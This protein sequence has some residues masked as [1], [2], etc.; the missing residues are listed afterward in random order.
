M[1]SIPYYAL[2]ETVFAEQGVELYRA[3]STSDGK[4]VLLKIDQ[5]GDTGM[6][7]ARCSHEL[8]VA[9]N[10]DLPC[11]CRPLKLEY[12]GDTPVLVM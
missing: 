3:F 5:C 9:G 1:I 12:C 11:I 7:A 2:L 6:A 8:A 10:L 4:K